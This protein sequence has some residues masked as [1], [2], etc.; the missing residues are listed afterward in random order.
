MTFQL[1]PN[2][3]IEAA[4]ATEALAVD[5][6]ALATQFD[7]DVVAKYKA[8]YENYWK[9]GRE[10]TVEQLQSRSDRMGPTELAILLKAGLF[11]Q[12]MLQ[13][14]APLETKYHSPPYEYTISDVVFEDSHTEETVATFTDL[15]TLV[16]T[17]GQFTSGK[18]VL[19]ELV[20]AWGGP[21]ND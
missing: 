21:T 19:G 1:P 5:A 7:S 8:M 4:L 15:Y 12:A 13:I 3:E 6:V 17:H 11:V 14:G 18:L 20:E 10:F 16:Q 2:P 9:I